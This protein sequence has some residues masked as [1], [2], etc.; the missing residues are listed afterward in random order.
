MD[1]IQPPLAVNEYSIPSFNDQALK[2]LQDHLENSFFL[3]SIIESLKDH[4]YL[5]KKRI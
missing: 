4:D 5:K 2:D 3:N 1:T